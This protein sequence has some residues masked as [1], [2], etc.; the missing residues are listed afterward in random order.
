MISKKFNLEL[1]GQNLEIEISSLAAQANGAVLARLGDTVV[2]ATAVMAKKAREGID[3]FPLS[4]DYEERFYAKGKIF[5]SRYVRRE[6]RAS[7]NAILNARLIDRSIRPLFNEK[8]RTDVQIV[9]TVLSIDEKNDPDVLGCLAASLALGIS[10]IHWNGPIG[11]VRIGQI[12]SEFIVNPTYQEREKSL[13]DLVVCGTEDKI[14]MIESGAKEIPEETIVRAIEFGQNYLNKLVKFQK[15]IIASHGKEK[16]VP[17]ISVEGGKEADPELIKKEKEEEEIY[18]LLRKNILEPASGKEQRPDGRQLDEIRPIEALVGFLPRTHGSGL[19]MRGT[20]QALSI[21]TLGAPGDKLLIQGMEIQGEKHFMHHYNFPPYSTGE[22]KSM[23]G[24]GRREIGHGALAEKALEPLVPKQEEFPY[25]I[26]IVSEILSSNGSSSMASVCGSSLALFDAGVP[27]KKAVA[28]IAMGLITDGEKY[29]ILTDIQGPED[30]Y[31]DMDFKAAGT[32]DG[33]TAIQ[34][35]VKINGVTAKIISEILNQSKKARLEILEKMGKIIKEPRQ[36][37]SVFAPRV[38]TLQIDAKKIGD[39]IGPQ[40]KIINE[41]IAQTGAAIDIEESGLIFITAD[42][43]EAAQKAVAWIKNITREIKAGEIFQGKVSKIMEF[44]AFVEI[45]PKQDG[46]VHISELNNNR[47]NK[48]TDVVQ[49]G[50]SVKVK[51]K[52]IDD[53]GRINLTMKNIE[54]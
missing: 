33:L 48:V 20:T 39:V 21:L 47:V 51:V 3:F 13:L 27:V 29:K 41:I 1:N 30:Y 53:L 40:G 17:E 16:F 7:D 22:I 8:G 25:T 9:I 35:D 24:P 23:R 44:G 32:R 18:N 34:M 14:N 38:L 5:G 42:N 31:G 28:G 26:R 36:N 50:Q 37:L 10:N 52:N 11:S 45:T 19:F 15:D 12:D 49:L 6:G 46:L 4:V 54:Q 43:E 2:L